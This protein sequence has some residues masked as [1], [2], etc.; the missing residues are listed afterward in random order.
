MNPYS[1]GQNK[2]DY[3]KKES[4][5]HKDTAELNQLLLGQ[6]MA[7]DSLRDY[8]NA[9]HSPSVRGK[10]EETL[11][12]HESQAEELADHIR[13]L[14]GA[15][16]E[17]RGMAGVMRTAK[18]RL[19]LTVDSSDHHIISTL[20]TGEEMGIDEEI[21]ALKSVSEKSRP[22]VQKHITENKALLEAL[23]QI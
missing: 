11:Q 13:G 2:L 14:G 18:T 1:L 6:H 20:I 10:L 22:L 9:A 7:I 5:M 12:A 15:P 23:R 21:K 19:S 17:S 8:I 3:R 16:Q 4:N